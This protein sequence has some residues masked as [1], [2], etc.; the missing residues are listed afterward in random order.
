MFLIFRFAEKSLFTQTYHSPFLFC[1]VLY[2]ELS[3]KLAL[4]RNIGLRKKGNDNG[5]I[6]DNYIMRVLLQSDTAGHY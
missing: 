6:G 2:W 4:K 3:N 5:F 1:K